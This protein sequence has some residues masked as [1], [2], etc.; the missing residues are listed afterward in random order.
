MQKVSFKLFR[1]VYAPFIQGNEKNEYPD[2]IFGVTLPDSSR[3][4]VR[5]F[6]DLK[7]AIGNIIRHINYLDKLQFHK[8][9][10][11]IPSEVSEYIPKFLCTLLDFQAFRQNWT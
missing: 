8:E 10:R 2:P 1:P 11:R 7:S 9:I 4:S 3:R 5:Y 6:T